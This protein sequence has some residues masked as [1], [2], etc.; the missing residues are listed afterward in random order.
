MKM[1]TGLLYTHVDTGSSLLCFYKDAAQKDASRL[2]PGMCS[3]ESNA[4][5]PED[6]T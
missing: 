6:L 4:Y 2:K 5:C 1:E 3:L